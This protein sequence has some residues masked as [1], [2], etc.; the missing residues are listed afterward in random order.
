MLISGM[1]CYHLE[2]MLSS[3]ANIIMWDDMLTSEM[4]C[5]HLDHKIVPRYTRDNLEIKSL[6]LHEKSLS[7]QIMKFSRIKS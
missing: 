2:L 4:K 5:Y 1:K 7:Y 3:G 6:D